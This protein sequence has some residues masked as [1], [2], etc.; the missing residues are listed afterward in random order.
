MCR[1]S[2]VQWIMYI[3]DVATVKDGG[4]Y[5]ELCPYWRKR[6]V[7]IN[8]AKAGNASTLDVVNT[9][10]KQLPDI[11]RICLMTWRYLRIWPIGVYFQRLESLVVGRTGSFADRIDGIVVPWMTAGRHWSWLRPFRSLLSLLSCSLNFFGQTINIMSLSGLAL[12]IGIL[13]DSTVTIENIHQHF[14]MGKTKAQAIW[15]ACKEIVFP[16]LLIMLC[17]LAVFAPAFMM[18]IGIPGSLCL[19]HW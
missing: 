14:A 4:Y 11:Q 3:R 19:C 1:S 8:I 15:D 16:K 18:T 13:V 2:R 12:A 17:I 7:Y 5:D 10:K 9:L 6:S